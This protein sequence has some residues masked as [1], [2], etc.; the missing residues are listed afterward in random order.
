MSDKGFNSPKVSASSLPLPIPYL[1]LIYPNIRIVR[2]SNLRFSR[3]KKSFSNKLKILDFLLE[4]RLL[5]QY[6]M[7]QISGNGRIILFFSLEF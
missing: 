4:N 6:T 3:S 2:S 1:N 7:V 5:R